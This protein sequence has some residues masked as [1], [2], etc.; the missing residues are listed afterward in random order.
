M[1]YK[2]QKIEKR[3]NLSKEISIKD[4]KDFYW[5]KKE[6]IEFCRNEGLKTSGGKIEIAQRIEHY[7]T[8]GLKEL[9]QVK[10]KTKLTSNFDWQNETLLR[11]TIITDNYKNTKNVRL[12]FENQIGKKFKFNIKFMNWMKTNL[13]KTLEDAIREWKRINSENKK[14]RQASKIAPQFEYNSYLRDF[15]IDNPNVKREIG[16]KLWNIKKTLR[17]NNKYKKTDLK[18]LK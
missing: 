11:E 15:L 2:Y 1:L 18:L 14:I 3:P 17:G 10:E 8:T 4:F 12:F 5:L 7:L 9:K 13:G 16:I 6:L